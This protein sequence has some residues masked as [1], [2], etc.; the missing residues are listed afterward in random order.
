MLILDYHKSHVSFRSVEFAKESGLI[1]LTVPP[2]TSH[3]LQPLDRTV[4]GPFKAH[5]NRA[6][7]N[8][9]RTNPG[10]TMT[11][12]NIPALVN[13]AYLTS[14]VPSNIQSGFKSTG[15]FPFDRDIFREECF[16]PAETTD[17]PLLSE[18]VLQETE[19]NQVDV[20][21][22]SAL[23]TSNTTEPDPTPYVSPSQVLP[24][25]IAGPRKNTSRGR[26]RAKTRILTDTPEKD[27]L[28]EQVAMSKQ[29]QRKMK[30]KTSTEYNKQ[31]SKRSTKRRLE[32][33]E[34]SESDE[35]DFD[36]SLHDKSEE[37]RPISDLEVH[38]TVGDFVLVKFS[39]ERKMH[40]YVGLVECLDDTKEECEGRFL[41]KEKMDEESQQPTF[42]LND[43]DECSF[44]KSDI[45]ILLPHRIVI[46][47]TKRYKRYLFLFNLKAWADRL[48]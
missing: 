41:K 38:V 34:S 7:D 4:F 12:Y 44:P 19:I 25:P 15:I 47:E 26:K 32:L 28:A 39:G 36:I 29:S 23:P 3:R 2:H 18:N 16:A 46:E 33:I 20:P 21:T 27:K 11:I 45:I 17:R 42:T 30:K 8:W 13:K 37:D 6:V 35:C 48:G 24:L 22:T 10:K 9:M 40:Y 43:G 31:K 14:F 5:Y 1:L